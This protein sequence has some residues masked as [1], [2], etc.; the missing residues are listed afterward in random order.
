VLLNPDRLPFYLDYSLSPFQCPSEAGAGPTAAAAGYPAFLSGALPLM[1]GPPDR[2]PACEQQLHFHQA[3][4][5]LA[6]RKVDMADRLGI[7]FGQVEFGQGLSARQR[8]ERHKALAPFLSGMC[9]QRGCPG[10][11]RLRR[12]VQPSLWAGLATGGCPR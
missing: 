6:V 9:E 3:I 12:G 11:A 8:Q 2:P 10:G 1:A 7:K 5:R 4:S